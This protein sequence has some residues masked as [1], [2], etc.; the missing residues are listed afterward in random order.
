[1]EDRNQEQKPQSNVTS[2][3]AES[4]KSET[5]ESIDKQCGCDRSE[6]INEVPTEV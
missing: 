6:N 3:L 4:A 1:M 2:D 5:E